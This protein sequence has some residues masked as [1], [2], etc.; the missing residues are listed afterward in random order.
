M[1]YYTTVCQET[2]NRQCSQQFNY[3]GI[4]YPDELHKRLRNFKE[5][6]IIIEQE[7]RI[8]RIDKIL[9]LERQVQQ[10]GP[11]DCNNQ[12]PS[13]IEDCTSEENVET[14]TF[15]N[16]EYTY[17]VSW[18]PDYRNTLINPRNWKVVVKRNNKILI[19]QK[20]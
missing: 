6:L 7:H 19:T 2:P 4:E 13:H 5:A 18:S 8:I 3:T 17:E 1:F 16:S 12:R 14:H 11:G 9:L 10:Q 20:E 15:R